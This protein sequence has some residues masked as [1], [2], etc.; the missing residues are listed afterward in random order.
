MVSARLAHAYRNPAKAVQPSHHRG[1]STASKETKALNA[2]ER[3]WR[4]INFD[5]DLDV[6]YTFRSAEIT[7]IAKAHSKKEDVVHKLLSNATQY[8]VT[9]RPN[10]R[11][12][13]IHDRSRKA[14]AGMY[15]ADFRCLRDATLTGCRQR[16]W[17]HHV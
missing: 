4:R 2:A 10:L 6:F 8:T 5:L 15:L 16:L 11:N 17:P 7:W 13:I 14:K 1:K 3:L 9:C 12:A